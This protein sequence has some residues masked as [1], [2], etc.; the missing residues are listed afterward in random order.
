VENQRWPTPGLEKNHGSRRIEQRGPPLERRVRLERVVLI[1]PEQIQRLPRMQDQCLE[2][3]LLQRCRAAPRDFG[4]VGG[5][6]ATGG[7]LPIEFARGE[8]RQTN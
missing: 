3:A 7:G 4:K 1:V 5:K 2:A 8:S 6:Q